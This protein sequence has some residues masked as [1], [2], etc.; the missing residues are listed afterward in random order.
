VVS[1]GAAHERLVEIVA[2]RV[3]IGEL[4]QNRDVSIVHVIESHGIAAAVVVDC[5]RIIEDAVNLVRV[6]RNDER[7]EVAQ[8]SRGVA[9]RGVSEVA[10]G[11]LPHLE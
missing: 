3:L 4:L 6:V 2:H 1:A 5:R 10:V 8:A 9:P 11:L 7:V